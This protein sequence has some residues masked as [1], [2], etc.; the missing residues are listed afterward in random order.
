MK[1]LVTASEVRNFH[2]TGSRTMM[3]KTG[4]IITPSAWDEARD[5][6]VNIEFG[7]TVSAPSMQV[8]GE[9]NLDSDFLAKV[10]TAVIASLQQ[11][12]GAVATLAEIDPSGLRLIH[13]ER[14]GFVG[15]KVKI[16]ELLEAKDGKKLNARLLK[17]S[18]TSFPYEAETDQTIYIIEGKLECTVGGITYQGAAGDSFY[19]PGRQKLNLGTKSQAFCFVAAAS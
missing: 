11:S 5:L 9:N 7:T 1:A 18:D 16:A 3:V 13:G 19:I 14:A 8:Q 6:G 4:D 17:L 15:E 12:K 10:V 2:K